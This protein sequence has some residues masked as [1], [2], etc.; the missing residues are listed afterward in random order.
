M[1]TDEIIEALKILPENDCDLETIT[2]FLNPDYSRYTSKDE[3]AI[4]K[5]DIK[6]ELELLIK[7]KKIKK[8]KKR[9]FTVSNKE[10]DFILYEIFMNK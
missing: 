8:R 10:D 1:L 7:E 5:N 6:S 9:I 3:K 2:I 4:F